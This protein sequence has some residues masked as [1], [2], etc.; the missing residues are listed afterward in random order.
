MKEANSRRISEANEAV[1]F[2]L[3]KSRKPPTGA[4]IGGTNAPGAKCAINLATDSPALAAQNQQQSQRRFQF[5]V[6]YRTRK[7][8]VSTQD[9][10]IAVEKVGSSANAV[11]DE[12]VA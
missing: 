6:A 4:K 3:S 9:L 8:N 5:E 2:A 10:R 12:L 11:E 1:N 7:L